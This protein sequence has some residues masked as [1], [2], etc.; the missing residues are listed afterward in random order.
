MGPLARLPRWA[1]Y[2][3]G[4]MVLLLAPLAV[5]LMMSP[6]EEPASQT[7]SAG[8]ASGGVAPDGSRS[9]DPSRAGDPAATSAHFTAGTVAPL[10]D[11]ADVARVR[12]TLEAVDRGDPA[13]ARALL[14][15]QLTGRFPAAGLAPLLE[16]LAALA[17]V[18]RSREAVLLHADALRQVVGQLAP[19]ADLPRH[20]QLLRQRALAHGGLP[21]LSEAMDRLMRLPDLTLRYPETRGEILEHHVL[22]GQ[23]PAALEAFR[24]HALWSFRP[25]SPQ[26][27]DRIELGR[28]LARIHA[29]LDTPESRRTFDGFLEGL[30]RAL[31]RLTPQQV[32]RARSWFQGLVRAHD[33]TEGY[34]R[35]A[36]WIEDGLPSS[37]TEPGYVAARLDLAAALRDEANRRTT[38]LSAEFLPADHD[39]PRLLF[40]LGMA[41]AQLGDRQDLAVAMQR[42]GEEGAG[43]GRAPVV[44]RELLRGA[45]ELLGGLGAAAATRIDLQLREHGALLG[46]SARQLWAQVAATG[47]WPATSR[48]Q[49]LFEN[50]KIWWQL[51]EWERLQRVQEQ[52]RRELSGREDLS[53]YHFLLAITGYRENQL[54]GVRE[55]LFQILDDGPPPG[56]TRSEVAALLALTEE[57]LDE[58]QRIGDLRARARQHLDQLILVDSTDPTTRQASLLRWQIELDEAP[59]GALTGPAG[60]ERLVLAERAL[61]G[62][63]LA[64]PAVEGWLAVQGQLLALAERQRQLGELPQALELTAAARTLT[65]NPLR[66]AAE[67]AHVLA[68][69]ARAT[70]LSED[71]ERRALWQR[72]GAAYASAASSS[73]GD[74]E[75]F[76]EAAEAYLAAG[77]FAAAG[78][79]LASFSAHE[80]GDARGEQRHWLKIL[81]TAQVLRHAGRH[82]DAIA[83]LGQHV[84]D[85]NAGR[86][87]YDLLLERARNLEQRAGSVS[88]MATTDADAGDAMG[89]ALADLDTIYNGLLPESRT[90]QEALERKAGLLERRL[91]ALA[92]EDPEVPALTDQ[93][94][95]L[96]EDLASRL[97]ADDGEWRLAE[98]LV[99]AGQIRAL[100]GELD[101]ARAHFERLAEAARTVL[102]E[103]GIPLAP[104]DADRWRGQAEKAAFAL[105]DTFYDARE[106]GRA[107]GEY[108]AA[109]RLYP[110][111]PL[112][113]WG[114]FRLGEIAAQERDA[115]TARRAYRF[116]LQK[117]EKLGAAE[118]R[119]LP[120]RRDRS[121]WERT[122]QERLEALDSW[123]GK[124]SP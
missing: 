26:G 31:V 92:P 117:L 88:A 24:A 79:A 19:C 3:G 14:G 98:A 124:G 52:L 4:A 22:L 73:G 102:D 119:E 66:F 36:S 21:M 105:A 57:R 53:A 6:A 28:T 75:L 68:S 13:Q 44:Y 122:I 69:M 104:A 111:S 96:W 94:L 74:P 100:R 51:R 10:S 30:P 121:F 101:A 5:L 71:A 106:P 76:F 34:D 27:L 112:A 9:P 62:R 11:P 29:H 108:E 86:L 82:D 48:G 103:P 49:L 45:Q 93:I 12:E 95:R 110:A 55:H 47:A 81:Y 72:C 78:T 41:A 59:A 1:L 18:E 65:G 46:E 64:F 61:A 123:A 80:R 56:L 58:L 116:A 54:D 77:E 40:R 115:G 85:P 114:N 120:P 70:S 17:E 83:L 37:V 35:G 118:L 20:L 107:R 8:G 16:R 63:L 43:A 38:G 25:D 109:C 91:S 23:W 84:D 42:L 50:G 32:A 39:R 67:E 113:V 15:S 90:W 2:A 97:V 33:P 7:A 89:L 99:R 60:A 87:R